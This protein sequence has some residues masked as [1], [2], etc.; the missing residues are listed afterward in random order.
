MLNHLDKNAALK[1]GSAF[2]AASNRD[3][4]IIRSLYTN[5]DDNLLVLKESK[6]VG[7]LK[8]KSKGTKKGS[9]IEV[10]MS[11]T[12]SGEKSTEIST[13]AK[14]KRNRIENNSKLRMRAAISEVGSVASIK[15]EIKK[16][17]EQKRK[18]LNREEKMR[19]EPEGG[20]PSSN[21]WENSQ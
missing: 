2:D 10:P 12:I 8:V 1:I 14:A 18:L 13:V 6:V 16:K 17:K 3:Q 9:R 20:F 15:R 5:D 21:R 7:L 11:E 4:T 19:R